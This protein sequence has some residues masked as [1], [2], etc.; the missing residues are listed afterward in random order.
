MTTKV[1]LVGA[2]GR[3]GSEVGKMVALQADMTVSAA[4]EVSGHRL[5]GSSSCGTILTADLERAATNCDVIVDFSL[6]GAVPRNAAVAAKTGKPMVCG[7]TG[8]DDVGFRHLES[9][10][11]SIPVVYATNF[12]VGVAAL[13]RLTAEAM[14]VLGK[15]FDVEIIEVHHRAKRDSPSGT[16]KM[17]ARIVQENGKRESIV[18]GRHGTTDGKPATEVGISSVRTGDVVGEHTVIFGGPGERL[19]L[20]HRVD[21][22][23][24]FASGVLMAIRFVLTRKPGLYDF[25]DVLGSSA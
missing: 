16:A 10:A 25:A 17:L 7:V 22:R 8:L 2:C 12:S 1:A 4:V 24:A 18:C 9:A 20:I 6:A 19:E 14:R 5:I 23:A 3:M 15:G 11:G 13:A 21:S